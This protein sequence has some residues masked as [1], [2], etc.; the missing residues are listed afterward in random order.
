MPTTG[1]EEGSIYYAED[2]WPQYDFIANPPKPAKY[3]VV[4]KS[5]LRA[6]GVKQVHI[7]GPSPV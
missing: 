1:N 3:Q 6:E 4:R 5:K 7:A 2:R